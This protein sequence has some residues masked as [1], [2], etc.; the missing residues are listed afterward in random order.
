MFSS[1]DT[2]ET[3]SSMERAL[4]G[5]AL[6]CAISTSVTT[7]QSVLSNSAEPSLN[8]V[9]HSDTFFENITASIIL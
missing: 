5:M 7:F 6:V 2:R 9:L 1:P 4:P 3:I 8:N